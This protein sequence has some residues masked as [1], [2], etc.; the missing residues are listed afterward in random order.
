MIAKLYSL[1]IVT[2]L[3]MTF[4]ACTA[5]GPTPESPSRLDAQINRYVP[6]EL[7]A[8]ISAL[9]EGDRQALAKLVQAAGFM[10]SLFL[11]QKWSGN[12]ALLAKLRADTSPEGKKLLQYFWINMGPWSKLDHD[13]PFIDGVSPHPA[14][15][16]YYPGD[17]TREEFNTWLATLPEKEQA[18]AKGFFTVIRR[19]PHGKLIIVPY[20]EEYRKFLAP[21][22]K[23]LKEAA[24]LTTNASLRT[25]LAARADAFSSDDY[26]ASD[27]AWMD[28]DSPV[29]VTIGPYE[30]Y[31]D[32]LFNYKAAFEAFITLRNAEETAKLQSFSQHLQDIENNLPIEPRYRNPKL[33]AAAPIRVVDEVDIGGEA[34]EGVKSAAFNLP[35]D[36]RVTREKGSKRVMLKNVQEAKFRKTL[37]PISEVAVDSTQRQLISFEPFF[38][39]IL[40]HELMHGLGPH[41]I[42]VNGRKTTVRQEMKELSSALEEAKADVSGLWALQYLIDTGVLDR[43]MEQQMYVTFLASIFRSIRFGLNEAHGRGMALQFN[44]LSDEGAFTFDSTAATFAANISKFKEGARKLTAEIMTIQAEGSYARAKE[45]LDKYVMIRPDMQKVLDRLSDVPTDIAP[46]F[47]LVKT[48]TE[49]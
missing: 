16:N 28:L 2:G 37:V 21:A 43:S 12:E 30:V 41:S 33:G 19:D 42:T 5:P 36:E 38:T 8:D 47:P 27:V 18:R 40:A 15:A 31:L 32:E 39:H 6:V 14:G 34:R 29:D 3:F 26:Y 1:I 20:S 10:D 46:T 45:L 44:Y 11:R 9:S 17:M 13:E 25:Y 23:L 4:Q 7:T 24:D 22:T 35:N 49:K 48:L